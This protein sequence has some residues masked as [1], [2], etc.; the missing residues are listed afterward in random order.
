M[1]SIISPRISQ[2]MAKGM[3]TKK[4]AARIDPTRM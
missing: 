4:T 2:A 3:R 1:T